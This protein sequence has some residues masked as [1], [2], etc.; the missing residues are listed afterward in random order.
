MKTGKPANAISMPRLKAVRHRVHLL[1]PGTVQSSGQCARPRHSPFLSLYDSSL[2]S[3]SIRSSGHYQD[4]R[5]RVWHHAFAFHLDTL[6]SGRLFRRGRLLHDLGFLRSTKIQLVAICHLRRPPVPVMWRSGRPAGWRSRLRILH[7][8]VWLL[9]F[10]VRP[11]RGDLIGSIL[12]HPD[13][14]GSKLE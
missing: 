10:G 7:P 8:S 1:P 6:D 14:R 5:E 9:A 13:I 2:A 4:P 12:D 3:V 11:C